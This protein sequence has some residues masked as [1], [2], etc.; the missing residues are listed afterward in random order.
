MKKLLSI[1]L[2]LTMIFLS[3]FCRFMQM[4]L[5]EKEHSLLPR[6]LLLRKQELMRLR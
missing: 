4:L 1:V 3:Q 5:R 6:L 2:A